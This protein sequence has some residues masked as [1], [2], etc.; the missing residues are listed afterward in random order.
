MS[1]LHLLPLATALSA[2][3]LTA[4]G[5]K[6][7]GGVDIGDTRFFPTLATDSVSTFVSDSGYTR[8]HITADRW[9]MFEEADT[10]FWSFP[11]GLFLQRFDDTM[12]VEATFRADSAI[13]W[14][15]KKIWQ[16]DGR[17]NMRNTDGDRF[18]TPQLF[19][20]QNEK[21][22]YSDSFMHIERADRVIEGYGFESNEQITKYTVSNPQMILP[23]E[24]KQRPAATG[25]TTG[26]APKQQD[27]TA[28]QP[29]AAAP[30]VPYTPV[31]DRPVPISNDTNLTR[32][33][34]RRLKTDK[35]PQTISTWTPGS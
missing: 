25:D 1:P 34:T 2:C 11:D 17:V 27:T 4:C 32:I 13:Y 3:I 6:D 30:D 14:S 8:Y 33:K 10:P 26:T 9:L 12:A 22:V 29:A 18:A 24:R 31:M 7:A 15:T 19:W 16:F 5:N 28:A 23:V 20:N 21:R 35:E